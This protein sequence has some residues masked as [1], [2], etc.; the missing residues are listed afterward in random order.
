MTLQC[1][2]CKYYRS[3]NNFTSNQWRKDDGISRCANCI[4]GVFVCNDYDRTFKNK[5]ALMMHMQVH[6]PRIVAFPICGEEI[7]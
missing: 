7:F 2:Q 5:N 3:K 1:A 6:L 4:N